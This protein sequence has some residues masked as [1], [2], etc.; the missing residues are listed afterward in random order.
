MRE[1]KLEKD[2]R[3]AVAGM[4]GI[5]FKFVSPSMNGVPDRVIA[6]PNGHV[7]F[8]EVKRPYVQGGRIR[9]LQYRMI[10]ELC[11]RGQDV[12]VAWDFEQGITA[13]TESRNAGND[14]TDYSRG[15][16]WPF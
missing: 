1:S 16:T 12:I 6:W 11:G 9:P 15:F 8:M 5:F 3:K 2:L 7:T 14:H 10:R 4:G 13:L